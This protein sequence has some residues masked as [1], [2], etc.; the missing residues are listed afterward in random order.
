[1]QEKKKSGPVCC[2]QNLRKLRFYRG[3]SYVALC[4]GI[5]GGLGWLGLENMAQAAICFLPDCGDKILE[6]QGD[7]NLSTQYCRNAGYTYYELGQ[8]PPY[9]HQEVC[10][11][12]SHYL[13]CD[14]QKWCEDNGYNT[15][16]EECVVPQ[17][18]DEQCLNGLNF[19]KQ[20]KE[21]LARAC[22]EENPDYVS[23]C[24][25]GWTFE[26]NEICTYSPLYGKCC[27]ECEDYPYEEDEIPQGYQKGESCLACGD[28][29]K[30]KAELND[31][32][33][34]GFIQCAN[35]GK[36]G[37]E[38]C[39][40]GDEKWYKECCA[41]CD[42]YPYLENQIPEGYVKGDS[43]DSCDGM[44]YKTKVGECATDYKW[45]NGACVSTCDKTC[46]VGNILY[47]DHTCSSCKVSGKTP[48]GVVSY[49]SGSTRLAINLVNMKMPW[50]GSGT[51]I[52]G[53]TNYTSGS[54][55]K[56]D[57]SGKSNTSIIV[58]ALGDTSSYA[59]GYCYNFTTSGTSKGDW[60][61]PAQGEL[62]ATV[63]TN[64]TA[65][66]SG[67]RA[68]GG[69]A[70]NNTYYR[71]SS[72]YSYTNAWNVTAN[73]GVNYGS[74]GNPFYVRCVLAFEDMGNGT[75]KVCDKEYI[76][77]CSV[78]SSTHITGGVGVSCGG[79][80]QSCQCAAG[81]EWK[82]GVCEQAVVCEVG[83][84]L[85]SDMTCSASKVSGKTPIGVVSYASGS[86]R[87]AINLVNMKMPWGGSGT[88]ISGLT[89]YTSGSTAKNDFS[90]KSNTSIIVSALGDTSS[91]AAGYC[92]NF[93][94]S[95][96]S[97]G[98]WY[99]P[100]QGE[101]YATVWTNKTAVNSGLRAAGGRA[102]NNIYYR[103]SSE[104]SA[105]YAWYVGANRGDVSRIAKSSHDY[106]RCVLAF[107]DMGNGTAKVCDKEYIY[108][109]SVDSSTHIT[110]GVGVSCGGLYQSCQCAAGYE[111]KNGVCE[112]AV[113]CEV[114]HILN[115]DMTCSASK[116]SGKT[117]IGVVSYASGSTRLAINLVNMKMPWGGSGTDISGL[118]NYT[119][120]STAKN[121]FSGK[122]N[123]S[124]IVSVLGSSSTSYAAGYC[125]NYTTTGTSKGQWYLPAEG[126]LYASIYTN[127]SAVN[128]GLSAAGGTQLSSNYYYWSS[129]EYS[130]NNAWDVYT[131]GGVSNY[132][133]GNSFYVRCVLAF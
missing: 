33:G 104:Y 130:Y 107:E 90:G 6:F 80:Y 2:G 41:P 106:V 62:Y 110:G 122:S 29:T 69:T 3:V 79:L 34:D 125:Y 97:K 71:S 75:A 128:S 30:Y 92:Y 48:I 119:S 20:C 4:L 53:L 100:A 63:W 129:S 131:N 78:D 46:S 23:E 108:S 11:D 112:Q 76:Y 65:V 44:K 68:A 83:H 54:T 38:V 28:I 9:Y 32:A 124:K 43:C 103:S 56:N 115:S 132:H 15:L 95:G 42:D 5:G 60:Y 12:N 120:G 109:C 59:A 55:A 17:Y 14:A 51:D 84:I 31:C 89:N 40:R 81:Y 133:K 13:K 8:C 94:T 86:T 7:A 39:W 127:Y 85:N 64:K 18:A 105:R 114:G 26:E 58:S 52:S 45:E 117:P 47:S 24:Q 19:Y 74:K 36:I 96:T 121:D 16:P 113:V 101:L 111:W 99:L 72:E 123:T 91:Y 49:A 87:L 61:L 88:D 102:I 77:S 116:V 67:L 73:G 66:N 82:N 27:N 10:P 35:G 25:E 118:T 1:M 37:T 21:D 93:T 22:S 57:F 70:I 98:D 50:G 126:E